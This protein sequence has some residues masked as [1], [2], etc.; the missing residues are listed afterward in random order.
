MAQHQ[1]PKLEARHYILLA[2]INR[3]GSM[4]AAADALGVTPSAVTHRIR[5]AERRLGISLTARLGSQF[6]L[7][8]SGKRLAQSAD[9][10]LDELFRAEID[11]TRIGRG[12]GSIVR[13]GMA[14]YNFFHWLPSFLKHLAAMD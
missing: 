1:Q 14:T 2:A 8:L 4:S 13:L 10:A 11:A 9:R 12:A 6:Q 7:T 5:E 3:L